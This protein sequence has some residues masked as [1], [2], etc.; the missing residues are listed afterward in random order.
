MP[1]MSLVHS[2]ALPTLFCLNFRTVV[3]LFGRVTQWIVTAT[4]DE[5]AHSF[6]AHEGLVV[7]ERAWRS[8]NE[9]NDSRPA[10]RLRDF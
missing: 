8:S 6:A 7:H 1:K 2:T 3:G 9:A 10:P 4:R 5:G